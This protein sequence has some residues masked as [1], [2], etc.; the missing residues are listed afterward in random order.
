MH[1]LLYFPFA[2]PSLIRFAADFS[3]P[4][5]APAL[6]LFALLVDA[7]GEKGLKST[8]KGNLPQSFCNDAARAFWGKEKYEKHIGFATI[9]SEMDF[10]EMHC[11][12]LAAEQAGLLRKYKEK[13]ILSVQCREK[14]TSHG[15]G[16]IY[17]DLFMAYVKKFNWAYRYGHQEIPFI[18]QSFLFTL[19]LL[20]KYGE[21]P[22]PRSFYEDIFL[23][24]FPD[25]LHEIEEVSY[26]SVGETLRNAYFYRTL[27]DCAEFF[28]LAELQ[29]IS[30]DAILSCYEVKKLPLLDQFISFVI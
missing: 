15:T 30:D 25:L 5:E 26:Q 11:L 20:S 29:A 2:T 22:R 8:A 13:F 16:A 1:R 18:Q 24:A 19:F 23:K 12:R 27:S 4:P 6:T 28:G 21:T 10:F 9:C 14:I 17:P 7:I 3:Q